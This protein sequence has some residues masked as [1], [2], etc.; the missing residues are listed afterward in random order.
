LLRQARWYFVLGN[1]TFYAGQDFYHT[2]VFAGIDNL[3]WKIVRFLRVD[4]VHSWDSYNNQYNG[5]RIGVRPGALINL[6]FD[7]A[8][9][10]EW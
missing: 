8:D 6:R 3:G 4:Y 7:D 10:A 1:N 2:E 5:V 9:G